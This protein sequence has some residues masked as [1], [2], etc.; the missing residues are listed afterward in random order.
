MIAILTIRHARPTVH[1]TFYLPVGSRRHLLPCGAFYYCIPP[2]AYHMFSRMNETPR[3]QVEFH[4]SVCSSIHPGPGL[5]TSADTGIEVAEDRD[6][7]VNATYMYDGENTALFEKT[8][9]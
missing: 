9:P 6:F 8:P 2:P 7:R 4:L 3:T 5:N 1:R